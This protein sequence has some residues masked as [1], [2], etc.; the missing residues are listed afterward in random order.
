M[1]PALISQAK[2]LIFGLPSMIFS[3]I[4]PLAGI[5]IFFYIMIRRIAPLVKSAPDYRFNRIFERVVKLIKIWLLQ[6][7]HPRY[8]LAGVLHILIFAGFLILSIRSITLVIIGFHEGF[9][10]PGFSGTLGHIYNLV[11]DYAAT[12]VLIAC[13]IL[14][15]RRGIFKPDRYAVPKKYGHDHTKVA[16]QECQWAEHGDGRRKR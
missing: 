6:Y 2:A 13:I 15:I 11:K 10:M 9:V 5:G 14:A 8:M 3:V 7:R 1:E 4:I 16:L 12:W